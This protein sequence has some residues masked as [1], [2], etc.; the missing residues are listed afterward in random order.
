MDPSEKT[1][2]Y[3][4]WLR[5]SCPAPALYGDDG[6]MQCNNLHSHPPIDFVRDSAELIEWKLTAEEYRKQIPMP[7]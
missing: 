2:R 3:L 4:L 7:E 1:L 5:H 6:E